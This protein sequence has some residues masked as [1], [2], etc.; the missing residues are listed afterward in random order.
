[1]SKFKAKIE[2][3]FSHPVSGNIDP[4][5]LLHALEHYGAKVEVTKQNKAKIF[6]ND[7]EYVMPLSHGGNLSKDVVMEVKHFLEKAGLTPDK[8]D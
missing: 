4:K 5:K 3:V 7:V 6:L 2:K 1:M 8:L